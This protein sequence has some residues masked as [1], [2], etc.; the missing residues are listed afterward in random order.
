MKAAGAFKI[1]TVLAIA[2]GIAW[3]TYPLDGGSRRLAA[4]A[5]TGP[6]FAGEDVRLDPGEQAV[7]GSAR[8]LK[9]KYAC[10]AGAVLITIVDGARNRHGVHD[11][12]YCLRG[13]G[14]QITDTQDVAAPS[15]KGEWIRASR[16]GKQS[17]ITYWFSE[18]GSDYASPTRYWMRTALRHMTLGRS[19]SE[20]LL[21]IVQPIGV[22]SVDMTELYRTLPPLGQF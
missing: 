3:E 16:D 2:L 19:G 18:P 21:V 6:G 5:L 14:W 12:V 20:P 1:G 11:P 9:R 7:Y 17:E 13:A 8:V 10:K 4:M 22:A 15:G